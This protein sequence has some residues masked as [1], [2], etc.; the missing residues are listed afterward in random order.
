[1][2]KHDLKTRKKEVVDKFAGKKVVIT[3]GTQGMGLAMVRALIEGGAEVLLTGRNEK[4]LEAARA[5]LGPKAHAVRSDAAS[6]PDVDALGGQ[7]EK[8][9]G[10]I[11][12]LFVNHGYA[13]MEPFDEV[14]EAS[15]DRQ[16]DV[17]TKGAFFTVQRL[18]PL[19]RDGGSVVFTSAVA[20]EGGAPGMIAYSASKAALWSFAQGFAAE[21]LPRGIRV[22][23]VSPGFIDTPSMGVDATEEWRT[24][25]SELGDEVTP[26]KRHG[27]PEEVARAALFLAFDATFTTAVKLP[28]D[29]GLGRG[30]EAPQ[31]QE[32]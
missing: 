20:D 5:E 8:T 25:F 23:A 15:F 31:R 26:M 29:G 11:D 9:L 17:N 30:I 19:I 27:T 12:A 7:V 32:A 21:L 1:M 24:G 6:M 4:N 14:T 28:V 18:A 22:N 10:R 16:F 13:R 2:C 3:G